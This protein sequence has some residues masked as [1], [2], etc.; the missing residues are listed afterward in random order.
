MKKTHDTNIATNRK[1]RHEYFIEERFEAGVVLE[2]WEVK[3]LRAG[4]VQLD[5][6][7]ILI[8]NMEAW[9][10]GALITPL[11]TA[12]THINPDPQ[13]SRKLLLHARELSKLVGS[14][15]RRGY[16]VVPLNLYWKHNRVK[17]E[18]G[19]AKGKKLHDKRETLKERDWERQKQRMMKLSRSS[20]S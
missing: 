14:V 7:Y 16:T 11:Q 6:A 8:K 1:A 20:N 3:S 5:Q 4:R 17:C 19:L 12:S 2:G 18:I 10:F 13:R 15:E 9:L